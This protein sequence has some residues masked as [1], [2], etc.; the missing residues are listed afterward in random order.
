MTHSKIRAEL[1]T[2]ST[3]KVEQAAIITRVLQNSYWLPSH[4]LL[5]HRWHAAAIISKGTLISCNR[6]SL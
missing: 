4:H 1:V 3:D 2:P 5:V 6:L